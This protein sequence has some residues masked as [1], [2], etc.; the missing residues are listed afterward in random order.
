MIEKVTRTLLLGTLKNML[1][2]MSAPPST[3]TRSEVFF[4]VTWPIGCT[5]YNLTN[6]AGTAHSKVVICAL[7]K[8]IVL[9]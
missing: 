1:S 6:T 5:M 4:F 8:K 7:H 9:L 3:K 2:P